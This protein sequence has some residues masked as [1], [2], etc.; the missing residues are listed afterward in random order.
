MTK[1]ILIKLLLLPPSKLKDRM[2]LKLGTQKYNSIFAQRFCEYISHLVN[3]RY[4]AD[5]KLSG[6]YLLLNEVKIQSDV[7][8]TCTNN[9]IFFS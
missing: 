2:N 8:G 3:R 7:F 6:F 9:R 5:L 4:M 1:S